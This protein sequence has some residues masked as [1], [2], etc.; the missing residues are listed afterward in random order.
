M[1]SLTILSECEGSDERL[2]SNMVWRCKLLSVTDLRESR[3]AQH[4]P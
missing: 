3:G 1:C 4:Q 2:F